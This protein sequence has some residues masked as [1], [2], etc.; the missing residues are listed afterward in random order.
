[1]RFAILLLAA[2][3]LLAACTS[4]EPPEP[5]PSPAPTL[6]VTATAE[7]TP[8]PTAA[9]PPTETPSPEQQPIISPALRSPD[10]ALIAY[11]E[12]QFVRCP[13]GCSVVFE[14]RQ[15]TELLRIPFTD[16]ALS[17]IADAWA[18]YTIDA[19][20]DDSS[21]VVL[22]G[23]CEC[24]GAGEHPVVIVKPDGGVIDSGV[25]ALLGSSGAHVSPNGRYLLSRDRIDSPWGPG[26][27]CAISGSAK[28]IELLTGDVISEVPD[29]GLALVDWQWLDGSNLAY[30]LRPFPNPD[31]GT[32]DQQQFEWRQLPVEWHL[33]TIP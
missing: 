10:G 33:L 24:D 22:G 12:F 32:C 17:R 9:V 26:V 28:L 29:V 19:W 23:S 25:S 14:D 30:A 15:G 3:T 21:G 6:D 11:V 4:D 2:L 5:T 20:L 8:S 13:P 7:P 31:D 16:P 18:A 1:M 27:G